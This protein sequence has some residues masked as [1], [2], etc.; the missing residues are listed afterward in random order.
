LESATQLPEI[1]IKWGAFPYA[2]IIGLVVV[3]VVLLLAYYFPLK[4][5]PKVLLSSSLLV[6]ALAAGSVVFKQISERVWLK[7]N[8][9][10]Q[11]ARRLI[12]S[13]LFTISS[14]PGSDPAAHGFVHML[15]SVITEDLP[16]SIPPP[17]VFPINFADQ[18]SPWKDVT[19]QNFGEVLQRLGSFQIMWGDRDPDK[20]LART[21][22]GIPTGILVDQVVPL[23][24]LPLETD[25]R[26][27]IDLFGDGYYRLLGHVALAE[28]LQTLR[29]AKAARTDDD[30][31]RLV[32][33]ARQQLLEAQGRLVSWHKD[34]VLNR[35]LFDAGTKLVA[36]ASTEA[37]LEQP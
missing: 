10:P 27:D 37:G 31:K 11:G 14:T 20:K 3:G 2:L 18:A 4:R 30:R 22:L 12:V 8:R 9:C 5:E 28:V 23:G 15:Q 35:N 29:D 7:A 26:R 36:Q 32:L 6:L 24:D 1:L 13:Q 21:Y 25:P 17:L 33:R 16:P 34:E 19:P